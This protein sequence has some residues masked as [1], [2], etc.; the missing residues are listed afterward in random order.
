MNK[1]FL[2]KQKQKQIKEKKKKKKETAGLGCINSFSARTLVDW[3]E[4]ITSDKVNVS[5]LF[6]R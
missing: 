1:N 4:E 2:P 3:L 6:Q 5:N